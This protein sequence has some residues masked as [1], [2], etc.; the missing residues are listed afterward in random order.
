MHWKHFMPH[1]DSRYSVLV[2]G[3]VNSR[4]MVRLEGVGK[5]KKFNNLIGNRSHDKKR[6]LYLQI[7]LLL[8]VSSHLFCHKKLDVNYSEG[9][10]YCH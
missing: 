3:W 8:N 6:I 7:S 1:E 5:L 9:M 4:A 2:R 10:P